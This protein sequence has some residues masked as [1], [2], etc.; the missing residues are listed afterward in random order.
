MTI[1]INEKSIV[2]PFS[3]LNISLWEINPRSNANYS[4]LNNPIR[5]ELELVQAFMPILVTCKF[6]NDPIKGD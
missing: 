5:P 2:F 4:K 1:I 3:H 6:D